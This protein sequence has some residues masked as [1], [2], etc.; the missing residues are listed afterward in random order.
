MTELMDA[1]YAPHGFDPEAPFDP[2]EVMTRE[3]FDALPIGGEERDGRPI[4]LQEDDPV[5]AKRFYT[6]RWG[7]LMRRFH[8]KGSLPD[9]TP[10]IFTKWNRI[11]VKEFQNA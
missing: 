5:E 7:W 4:I 2:P 9:G 11:E 8:S 3:E 6:E 10:C 1:L